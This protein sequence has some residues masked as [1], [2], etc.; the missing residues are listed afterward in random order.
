MYPL[1]ES[2]ERAVTA[3]D[4]C[5]RARVIPVQEAEYNVPTF[6]VYFICP[7]THS[8]MAP[9]VRYPVGIVFC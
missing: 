1:L 4:I 6:E 5:R 8:W 9:T 2:N 3:C 7:K